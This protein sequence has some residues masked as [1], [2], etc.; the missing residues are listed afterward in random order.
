MCTPT[1]HNPF[2]M[3]R[4][5]SASS[6]SLASF[7][8][9]VKVVTLR[10][11]SRLAISSGV[12]SAGILSAAVSTA[13]GYTY[14]KPNSARMACISVVLSPALPNMSITCPMGFFALS[15]HSVIFTIALSPVFPPFSL[16]FGIN[17]SLASVRFSVTRNAYDLA[18]SNVP[19]KVSLARSSISITSPSASLFFRLA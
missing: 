14:G 19:T 13:F 5:E 1:S 15:G 10:K 2:L 16:S 18:T 3:E 7:G 8:S 6:K 4:M 9:I 11:S 17:M 12:I